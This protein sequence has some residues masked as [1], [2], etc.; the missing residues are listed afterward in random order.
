[1]VLCW[2]PLDEL[3]FYRDKECSDVDK[4]LCGPSDQWPSTYTYEG[5]VLWCRFIVRS[6]KGPVSGGFQLRARPQY[7]EEP[8]AQVGR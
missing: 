1:M 2:C 5:A 4:V 3:V 8:E 7:P 6:N